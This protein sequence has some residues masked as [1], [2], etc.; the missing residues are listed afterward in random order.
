VLLLVA[1]VVVDL[2]E[3][4]VDLLEVEVVVEVLL[5]EAVEAATLTA[6]RLSHLL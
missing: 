6:Q 1:E 5:E 2:L 3:V 4:V